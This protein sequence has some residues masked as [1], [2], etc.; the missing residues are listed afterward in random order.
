MRSCLSK[1]VQ[2]VWRQPVHAFQHSRDVWLCA[3]ELEISLGLVP[4]QNI[5]IE[6]IHSMGNSVGMR[7]QHRCS[8]DGKSRRQSRLRGQRRAR[9]N[10]ACG[11]GQQGIEPS[12]AHMSF[13]GCVRLSHTWPFTCPSCAPR[14]GRS[15]RLPRGRCGSSDGPSFTHTQLALSTAFFRARRE[16]LQCRGSV[17]RLLGC[18]GSFFGFSRGSAK[19]SDGGVQRA[20]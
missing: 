9:S 8:Q 16:P 10:F 11:V 3:A 7:C 20:T 5:F 13:N 14:R 15:T 2:S 18:S 17:R 6:G 4:A 1:F 12:G 19:A